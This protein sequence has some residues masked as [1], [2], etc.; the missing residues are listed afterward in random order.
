MVMETFVYRDFEA[1]SWGDD[2]ASE[3]KAKLSGGVIVS[4]RV[5]RRLFVFFACR[6]SKPGKRGRVVRGVRKV[7]G[8]E[9][10]QEGW[11]VWI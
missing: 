7:V 4:C 1:F 2:G 9:V 10:G 5:V 11:R 6:V 3:G 8:L